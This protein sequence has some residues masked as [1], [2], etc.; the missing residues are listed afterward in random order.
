MPHSRSRQGM[1]LLIKNLQ[2][3]PVVTIQGVRQ[4]G[5]SF[6]V[7]QL[8]KPLCENLTY[9]SFDQ[10]IVRDQATIN[11][12]S[13][14]LSHPD[15]SPFAIDEAQKVPEIFDAIKYLV[16]MNRQ[17]GQFLLLGSTEFSKESLI[18][19]SLTG[20]RASIRLFPFNIAES[21]GRKVRPPSALDAK[22]KSIV[23]RKEFLKH[24]RQGG[25]PGIFF[26][27]D[28]SEFKS[29]MQDWLQT[30][31]YRDLLTFPKVKPSPE[32][33]LDILTA[34]ANLE[35]TSASSIAKFLDT[36]LRRIKSHLH[37]LSLLFVLHA[38]PP[39]RQST[40]SSQYFL[41]DTGLATY[42][43]ANL[44]KQIHTQLIWERVSQHMYS[45]GEMPKIFFYKS[46]KG[47]IIHLLEEMQKEVHAYQIFSEEKILE[48][49]LL[50]LVSFEKKF[51]EHNS[52]AQSL[53]MFGL[54][55]FH[56]TTMIKKIPIL[57]WELM[58]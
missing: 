44:E 48:R 40:G 32:L 58:A 39:F 17:P 52:K 33:A 57:P 19:E 14:L 15:A 24:L 4:C 38:L 25:F 1:K 49:D 16:D 26:V 8:L 10:K 3:Q 36:D 47:K 41:A 42:L 18:R 37:L 29:L 30:T 31:I 12:E 56:E 5:K 28:Q 13:F 27:R 34:C 51:S 21:N 22:R 54:G 45:F 7:R 23:G 20:R 46:A 35:D 50:R 11:P 2:F 53:K 55:S 43:G 6:L 9:V